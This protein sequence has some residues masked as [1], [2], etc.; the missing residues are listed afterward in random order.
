MSETKN[1][2][3]Q[4]RIANETINLNVGFDRQDDVRQAE[5]SVNELYKRWRK[6]F[7]MRSDTE[8]LAM[9]SYQFAL[10]YYDMLHRGQR[11]EEQID[12]IRER[13]DALI[14]SF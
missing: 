9:I 7:P 5:K 3:M 14:S 13:L 6:Q 11:T 2:K 12:R 4:I 8:L 1:V 10:Y